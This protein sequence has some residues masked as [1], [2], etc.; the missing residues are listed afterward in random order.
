MP[1]KKSAD[2]PCIAYFGMGPW[3]IYVGFTDSPKAF[4]KEMKRLKVAN[5]PEF[6]LNS[7][8]NATAHTLEFEGSLTTII[9]MEPAKGK[10]VEQVAALIAHEAVH[11]AQQL[12]EHIGED[13]PGR[14]AEAYLVQMVTQCCLEVALATGRER[15][16]QP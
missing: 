11:V 13:R 12:W 15:K 3:P 10:P 1:S 9:T 6:I 16:E 2:E 5:P 7:H 4:R 8:S 14:E